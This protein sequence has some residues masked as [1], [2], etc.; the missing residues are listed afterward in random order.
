[1]RSAV[2]KAALCAGVPDA[3]WR[4]LLGAGHK[5]ADHDDLRHRSL[6]CLRQAPN[7]SARAE[8]ARALSPCIRTQFHVCSSQNH[9]GL[10]AG[11]WARPAQ[12][13]NKQ[14]SC[15]RECSLHKCYREAKVCCTKLREQDTK[16]PFSGTC[17]ACNRA[18]HH[19]A[20]C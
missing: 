5:H 14:T 11:A 16:Q 8:T 19:H 10:R 20:A 15:V 2:A 3:I 4:E 18:L 12:V 1:M 7:F 17:R 13:L 6:K 9:P